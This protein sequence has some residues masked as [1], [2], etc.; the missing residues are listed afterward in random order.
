MKLLNKCVIC[1]FH[2]LKSI[3]NDDSFKEYI[4]AVILINLKYNQFNS[5]NIEILYLL[6]ALKEPVQINCKKACSVMEQA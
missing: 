2:Y 3:L 5:E 1:Y 6:S 4:N